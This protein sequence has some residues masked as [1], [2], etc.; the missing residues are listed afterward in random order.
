MK[1]MNGIALAH[2]IRKIDKK[3]QIIFISGYTDYIM[4]GYD[5]EALHYIIKPVN[6]DKL[7]NVLNRAVEKIQRNEKVLNL[8]L[9][10]RLVRISISD[11]FY[12]EVQRNYVTIHASD[13]YIKKIPLKELEKEL[14]ESFFRI[15]RSYI[16]NLRQISKISKNEIIL[17]NSESIPVPRGLYDKI[18]RAII[19][20]L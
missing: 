16:V 4:E 13:K 19:E 8:D 2:E 9:N 1:D 12:L 15:G 14:D 7:F 10:D 3:I 18:N 6:E 5:V 17:S 20:R 11:I